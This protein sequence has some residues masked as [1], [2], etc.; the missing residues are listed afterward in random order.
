VLRV[1]WD[2]RHHG[3]ARLQVADGGKSLQMRRVAEI[4]SISSCGQA[5]SGGPPAWVLGVGLT[6]PYHKTLS[7]YEMFQSASDLD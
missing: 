3:M 7:C 4:Y 5:T 2:P 6:I 1:R